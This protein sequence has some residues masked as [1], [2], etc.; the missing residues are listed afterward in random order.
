MGGSSKEAKEGAQLKL[1]GKFTIRENLNQYG[2][3][4]SY[5]VMGTKKDGTRPRPILKTREEAKLEK[6]RLEHET[7]N[8]E[9]VA[10]RRWY[11]RLTPAQ[12]ADAENAVHIKPS[13][14]SLSSLRTGG[15]SPPFKRGR[16]HPS[17]AG[18]GCHGLW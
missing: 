2:E 4:V 18:I 6:E 9:D 15:A 12:L 11:T 8:K 14:E 5:T 17:R 1:R 3:I 10:P 7:E 13:D 16:S